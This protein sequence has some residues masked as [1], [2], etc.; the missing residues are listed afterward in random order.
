MLNDEAKIAEPIDQTTAT[1]NRFDKKYS[2]VEDG[3]W[4]TCPIVLNRISVRE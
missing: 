3:V 1:R 4:E 2:K